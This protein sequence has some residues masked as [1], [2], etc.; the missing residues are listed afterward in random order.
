M[1]RFA[2]FTLCFFL[3]PDFSAANSADSVEFSAIEI[4]KI[5]SHGPWPVGTSSDDLGNQ[6]SQLPSVQQFGKALFFD[7]RLSPTRSVSCATCHQPGKSFSD[8][9]A[10]AKGLSRNAPSLFNARYERWFGWDGASDSIW[11]QNLRPLFDSNEMGGSPRYLQQLVASSVDLNKR[12]AQLFKANPKQQT[13]EHVTV[14]LAKAIAAYVATLESGKTAF[15]RFRDAL[16]AGDQRAMAA[17]PQ[18]AQRGLKLFIGKGQCTTCHVGPMFSNGEF[19]DIGINFFIRPGVVDAGRY[20][21]LR[22]LAAS[23]FNLVSRYST[24]TEKQTEKTRLV[25]PQHRN[26]GEFKVPSLRNVGLTAPYM[27][28]GSLPTLQAVVLHYSELNLDRLHADG[29]QI[30]RPLRLS[31]TEQADLVAFL[32]SL[33]SFEPVRSS[34]RR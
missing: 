33:S 23:R 14:N 27:H 26:F 15:D 24:A 30:L 1:G 4:R 34:R 12:Y 10:T 18:S 6:Y 21:G 13:A 9:L 2:A 31:V 5:N 29:D 22:A 8:G 17:Y 16:A 20:E 25:D 32:L 19:A 7:K 3:S 11:S 28:N